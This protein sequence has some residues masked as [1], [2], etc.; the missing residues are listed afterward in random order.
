M[1]YGLTECG[2]QSFDLYPEHYTV[3]VVSSMAVVLGSWPSNKSQVHYLIITTRMSQ[4]AGRQKD[5]P[6]AGVIS[7]LI[8]L[9]SELNHNRTAQTSMVAQSIEHSTEQHAVP[10]RITPKTSF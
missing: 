7:G 4:L 9:C 3:D 6:Y 8:L 10:V 2:V 1:G 5:K